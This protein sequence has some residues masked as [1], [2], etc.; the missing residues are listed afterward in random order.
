MRDERG[1]TTDEYMRAVTVGERT[2]HRAPV[3][4]AE[5]DS[6]WPERFLEEEAKVRS[7]LGDRALQV[8]HVGSTSVPNLAAKPIVDMVLVVADSAREEEYVPALEQAGYALTIRESDWFEHR[9]LKTPERD[10][11]LHVFSTGCEEVERML[12]F[13][14]HLRADDDDRELYERT[15]RE[16][17]GRT[18]EHVQHYADSKTEVVE[19]IMSRVGG[20]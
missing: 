16:L 9:L 11:H 4:L 1:L 8:E 12:A 5:Y 2:P 17:A 13:R 14:E 20:S 3:D 15:K 6:A 18:W 10:V 7:A 19:Q